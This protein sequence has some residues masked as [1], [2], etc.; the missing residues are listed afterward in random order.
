MT[1]PAVYSMAGVENCISATGKGRRIEAALDM[2]VGDYYPNGKPW[3]FRVQ[4]K[5]GK[6][7]DMPAHYKAEE[8]VGKDSG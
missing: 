8:D 5:G 2:D 3:W 7:H 4:E 1:W 6:S